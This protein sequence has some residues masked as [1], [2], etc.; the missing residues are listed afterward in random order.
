MRDILEGSAQFLDGHILLSY[1]V[2]GG[3]RRFHRKSCNVQFSIM[4]D[5]TSPPTKQFPGRRIRWA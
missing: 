4:S 5:L 2:V 3:A 1:A